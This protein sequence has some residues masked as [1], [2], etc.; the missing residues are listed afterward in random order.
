MLHASTDKLLHSLQCTVLYV[1]SPTRSIKD[2]VSTKHLNV[3]VLIVIPFLHL[4]Q[5]ARAY[6]DKLFIYF[7]SYQII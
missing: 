2:D 6:V 7:S 5:Q 1:L 4:T 3:S